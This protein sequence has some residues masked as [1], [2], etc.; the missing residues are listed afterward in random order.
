MQ[1][2]ATLEGL[3]GLISRSS[4]LQKFADTKK[5]HHIPVKENLL[6]AEY[7]EGLNTLET[8]DTVNIVNFDDFD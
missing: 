5:N 7:I 8:E 1:Q 4:G 2:N 6:A 3:S